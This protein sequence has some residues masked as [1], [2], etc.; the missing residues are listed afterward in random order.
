MRSGDGHGKE[1]GERGHLRLGGKHP[2]QALGLCGPVLPV[3]P[4]HRGLC[5][6]GLLRAGG[7]LLHRRM[8]RPLQQPPR[9][10]Y[11]RGHHRMG[12]YADAARRHEADGPHRQDRL[13][14]RR[15]HPCRRPYGGSCGL[16]GHR[17]HLA[18]E[19][20]PSRRR[21]R[22]HPNR[23]ARDLRLVHPGLCRR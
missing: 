21:A 18:A 6:H 9:H 8:G 19:P 23:H 20:E 10:V 3:V 13:L 5:H 14:R 16:S 22:L 11:R 4:D 2:G 7:H 12:A 17:R 15:A 1:L